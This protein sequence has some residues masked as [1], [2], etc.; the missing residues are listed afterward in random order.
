MEWWIV[1]LLVVGGVLLLMALG[2][3]VAFSFLV[4]N[5]TVSAL[6][7][8]GEIGLR[9]LVRSIQSSVT[10]FALVPVPLFLL[11]GE[12]TFRSGVG[13]R[14]MDALDKVLGGIPGRLSLLAVGGGALFSTLSGSSMASTAMLGHLLVPDMEKRGYH[15]S[16]TIG[17]ILGSGGL[18]VMIP[19]SALAVLLASLGRF[20]V[21][22]FLLAIVVPGMLMALLYTLY[23]V[24]RCAIRPSL[25]PRQS[26]ALPPLPQRLAGLVV[27]VLPIGG[28]VFLVIGLI[29]LGVATP[30]ESAALGALGTLVL[31]AVYGRLRWRTFVE[32]VSGTTR[33]S[34]MLLLIVSGSAAFSQLLAFSGATRSLVEFAVEAFPGPIA[35]MIVMQLL[36]LVLGTFME[37]LS[38][39]MITLPIYM[40]IAEASG[41]HPLWFGA[42]M[43]LNMQMATTTPPFGLGLFVMKGVAPAGTT[44][45]QIYR[46]SMPFLGLD[47]VVMTLMIAFPAMVLWLPTA[48]RG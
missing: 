8:G 15:R 20:S 40:P 9:Q 41:F 37:P 47:L 16:M 24:T 14:M 3:P 17:P 11:M 26:V 23:V 33:V 10:L 5:L 46:A 12:L 6:L 32:A 38:I 13:S 34:V 21:G 35:L 27:H 30:S 18:S 29:V 22:G 2:M 19:P 39:M 44:M 36:L 1:L 25:A 28:I 48:V 4:V 43:L 42:V 45:P 7:W 31:A